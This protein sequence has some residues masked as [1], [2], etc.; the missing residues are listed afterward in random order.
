MRVNL[1]LARDQGFRQRH[2]VAWSVPT[3]LVALVLLLRM[4]VGAQANWGE[5]RTVRASADKEVGRQNELLVREAQLARKLD[6][7]DNRALL[8]EVQFINYLIDERRLSFGELTDKVTAL[9]PPQ[10]RLSGLS[11]PDASGDPVVHFAIEGSGE[12]PVETFLTNLENSPDFKDVIITNQGFEEKESGGAPVSITC[13]ARYVG[14]RED[15]SLAP[16]K[17]ATPAG[18]EVLAAPAPKIKAGTKAAAGLGAAGP[19]AITTQAP[20]RAG[21]A[22]TATRVV[23]PATEPAVKVQASKPLG[24]PQVAPAPGATAPATPATPPEAPPQPRTN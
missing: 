5:Y 7:P 20:L 14:G 3:L 11:M 4:I 1:N 18:E 2:L 17:T 12:E 6:E 23:A 13:N 9:L 10:A 8:H 21:G 16:V 19:R 22:A 15:L 24:S